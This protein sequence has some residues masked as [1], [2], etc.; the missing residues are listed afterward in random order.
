MFDILKCYQDSETL[1]TKL[2]LHCLTILRR[3]LSTEKTKPNNYRK[4]TRKPQSQ[5]RI[6]Y[7]DYSCYYEHLGTSVCNSVELWEGL[8]YKILTMH[9]QEINQDPLML[10]FQISQSIWL[11]ASV[12]LFWCQYLTSL[13]EIILK[14]I[15]FKAVFCSFQVHYFYVAVTAF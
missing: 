6:T 10:H 9:Y 8:P 12:S 7:V 3:D 4:M 14:E 5:V 15:I 11:F 13:S 2:Q 1:A